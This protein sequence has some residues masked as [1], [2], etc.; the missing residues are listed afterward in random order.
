MTDHIDLTPLDPFEDPAHR[1]R[2]V[3]RVLGRAAP[4]LARRRLAPGVW[5]V[6]AAWA[7]PALAAAAL[8]VVAAALVLRSA[9]D[10]PAEQDGVAEA[11]AV[12][13]PAEAWRVEERAPSADDLVRS[14]EGSGQWAAR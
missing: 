12:P 11:L 9:V 14:V 10:A 7:R 2:F 6:V 1:D 3:G 8:A 13:T 5:N 4:E